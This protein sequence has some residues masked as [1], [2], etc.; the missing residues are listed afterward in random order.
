MIAKVRDKVKKFL[1]EMIEAEG[2]RVIRIDRA[3]SGW[4]VEAEVAVENQYLASI[5]PEYRVF[6][7]EYYIVKLNVDLEVSSYKR[8]S[9][10]EV[11]QEEAG[12][13]GL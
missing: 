10:S 8:V 4:V 1:K 5:K 11:V 7:K 2:V 13:Y 6:E 9:D 3:D 12:S